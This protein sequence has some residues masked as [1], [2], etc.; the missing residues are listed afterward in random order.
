MDGNVSLFNSPD[1]VF[2]AFRWFFF[3]CYLSLAIGTIFRFKY[4][5]ISGYRNYLI[6]I[7]VSILLISLGN[8]QL[9]RLLSTLF[10]TFSLPKPFEIVN[11]NLIAG[12]Y[13]GLALTFLNLLIMLYTNYQEILN[14]RDNSQCLFIVRSIFILLTVTITIVSIVL[15]LISDSATSY[16][17]FSLFIYLIYFIIII[18][19]LVFAILLCNIAKVIYSGQVYENF[20][21]NVK[22]FIF[23]TYL[24]ALSSLSL[25]I[26]FSL[27]N[28]LESK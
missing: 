12:F 18:S 27:V 2:L 4:P 23:L 19:D 9:V 26:A 10:L 5:I 16:L 11:I 24:I 8:K 6:L 14:E 20:I 13:T 17:I 25:K 21:K 1:P 28:D 7:L 22:M 15:G 3:I